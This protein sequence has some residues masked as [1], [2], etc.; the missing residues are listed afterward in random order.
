MTIVKRIIFTPD[1]IVFRI[2]SDA[3]NKLATIDIIIS[4]VNILFP[5]AGGIMTANNIPYSAILNALTILGGKIFPETTPK[6][7]LMPSQ[8]SPY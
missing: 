6:M 4:T 7:Y 3:N 1:E 2:G 5:L 8:A